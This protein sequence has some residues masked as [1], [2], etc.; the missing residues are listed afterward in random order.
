MRFIQSRASYAQ[1][2]EITGPLLLLISGWFF[3]FN[4]RKQRSSWVYRSSPEDDKAADSHININ[5]ICQLQF[6]DLLLNIRPIFPQWGK[7]KEAPPSE[8]TQEFRGLR[9][10]W[11]KDKDLTTGFLKSRQSSFAATILVWPVRW[12]I[13]R[14]CWH[15]CVTDINESTL[16]CFWF[17][18]T[19]AC[20]VCSKLKNI[21]LSSLWLY[22]V[23]RR[24][25]WA[26]IIN[27][28]PE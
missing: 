27:L 13:L 10:S 7:L 12:L 3:F 16:L 22:S 9:H 19:A 24:K 21:L 20:F 5:G 28:K 25:Y 1:R 2:C 17:C 8:G 4:N 23:E 15:L 18:C 26:P 6:N 11:M 14:L